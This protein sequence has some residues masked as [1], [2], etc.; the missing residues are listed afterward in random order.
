MLFNYS[1]DRDGWDE[2]WSEGLKNYKDETV[3]YEL[4]TEMGQRHGTDG[5]GASHVNAGGVSGVA[6]H[7]IEVVG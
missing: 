2:F 1:I 5:S 7:P 3:F 4:V 6:G